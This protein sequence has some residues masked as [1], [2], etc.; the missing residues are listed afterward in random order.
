MCI[1]KCLS[2]CYNN[3]RYKK[4]DKKDDE[5][6]TENYHQ[7]KFN[8]YRQIDNKEDQ[9]IKLPKKEGCCSI[10]YKFS[11]LLAITDINSKD[12]ICYRCFSEDKF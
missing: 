6:D 3:F 2:Y 5:K 9:W 12:I 4:D 11:C 10:C 1:L 7:Q 8:F